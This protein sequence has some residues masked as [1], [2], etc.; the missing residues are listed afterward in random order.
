MKRIENFFVL[1]LLSSVCAC[2]I[3]GCSEQR[4]PEEAQTGNVDS[5]GTAED[6]VA[7]PEAD[8]GNAVAVSES[9]AVPVIESVGD[10]SIT[11]TIEP[12]IGTGQPGITPMDVT[13]GDVS[14]AASAPVQ[15]GDGDLDPAAAGE[16]DDPVSVELSGDLPPGISLPDFSQILGAGDYQL[17]SVKVSV[18]E[19]GEGPIGPDGKVV[20]PE[21]FLAAQGQ[22]PALSPGSSPSENPGETSAPSP[23]NEDRDAVPT[24]EPVSRPLDPSEAPDPSQLEG[25][26]Q[27]SSE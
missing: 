7:I 22:I 19:P 13:L 15:S 27:K 24:A 6:G 10:G 20:T 2:L 26:L 5:P 11:L 4:L 8:S 21:A 9:E 12:G 18:A 3:V 16:S 17:E 25:S 1:G 14:V 23:E